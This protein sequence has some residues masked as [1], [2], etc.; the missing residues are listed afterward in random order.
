MPMTSLPSPYG[1]GTMGREAFRF[2]DFLAAAGQK[3]WQLLPLGPTGFGDSPYSSYSSFAGNPYLIDL[4]LLIEEGLL[5]QKEVDAFDWGKEPART[6]YGKLYEGRYP[7]LR[8]AF[9]RGLKPLR[10][11]FEAFCKENERW[12]DNYTLY[13]AVKAHFGMKSWNA[14]PEEGIRKHQPEAVRRYREL[15]RDEVEFYRFV[16]FLFFRQWKALKAYAQEK[17]VQFIGDI[18]IYV[19]MDSADIWAEPQFFQ[20]D[21]EG[22][23]K[24]IAGV[25]PDPFTADGQLWGNPLYDWE[26]MKADGYGWWIRRI[27]GATKLFDVLRIDHFR[28]MESYWAVPY[29]DKT[30]KNGR[31]RQGPG[32]SLVGVLT[33]WFHGTSFI[34][35][36]LGYL[37]PEVKQLLK[38]SGLP[39]MR[40]MEFAF[41]A[42]GESDYLP[43]RCNENSVC[44]LGTHDNDTVQGWLATTGEEDLEF[45]RRYMHITPDEGWNWGMIRSG[46]ATSSV[47]F[48]VQMQ[49]LLELDGSARMNLPGS[50]SGNWQWRMLPGAATDELAAKLRLYTETFRRTEPL[51]EEKAEEE[52][53]DDEAEVDKDAEKAE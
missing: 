5:T 9:E 25:P 20:L 14:W 15:L 39:G 30:A 40:V 43:H 28:G 26:R 3:Y 2:V 41:D 36:D 33:S 45:A 35:E 13:T 24:E 51:P 4:D 19:A 48:V 6:D 32:M 38:D 29:G 18:P 47:L 27:E 11:E 44:Y 52:P 42:H 12:L 50:D 22:V 10:E 1:V 37:T 49:D 8:K 16:Q 46:M 34:A 31:W 23:P 53:A 17:G 7:L 21:S